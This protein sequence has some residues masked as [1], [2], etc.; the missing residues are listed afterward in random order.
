MTNNMVYSI[1][2]IKLNIHEV[3][4]QLSKDL[5]MVEA[6]NTVV[7]CKRNVPVAELRPIQKK[8]LRKPVLGSARGAVRIEA[9]FDLPLAEDEL[10]LWHGIADDDPLKAF[11][12]K[13]NKRTK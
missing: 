10:K 12:P 13:S 9:D 1:D 6:G 4:A 8:V 11:A 7:I 2:M 5:E 3:K